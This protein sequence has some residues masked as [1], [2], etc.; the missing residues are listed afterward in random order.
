[1]AFEATLETSGDIAKI[2]LVGE[3]DANSAGDFR[4]QIEAASVANPQKPRCLLEYLAA[5]L[6]D[7][8]QS[9]PAVKPPVPIAMLDNPLGQLGADS[10]HVRQQRAAGHVDVDAY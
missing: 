9:L 2:T 3:L 4:T 7:V 1:M 6:G 5:Q 10:G 8:Q